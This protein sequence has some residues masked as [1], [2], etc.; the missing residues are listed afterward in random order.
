MK[1]P[2]EVHQEGETSMV[3]L[4]EYDWNLY[5]VR[6]I[7]ISLDSVMSVI[8]T[9]LESSRSQRW[10]KLHMKLTLGQTEI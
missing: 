10:T 2:D 9:K 3:N 4:E 6:I 1:M 8:F 7:Y 5:V